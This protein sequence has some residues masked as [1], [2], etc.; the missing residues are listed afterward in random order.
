M[1]LRKRIMVNLVETKAIEFIGRDAEPV[2][3]TK[4]TFLTPDQEMIHGY[5]DKPREDFK[6]KE[7]DTDVFVESK[8]I[9]TFWQGKE[10][11]GQT[12]WRLV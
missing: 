12:T 8:A 3:K 7:I 9:E 1:A 10:Y 11:Q 5:T 6:G 2:K 4:Y